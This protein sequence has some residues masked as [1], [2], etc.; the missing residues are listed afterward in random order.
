M[1]LYLPVLLL[2]KR[3]LNATPPHTPTSQYFMRKTSLIIS[4]VVF[5]FT[6]K[7]D[8]PKLGGGGVGAK[9]NQHKT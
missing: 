4:F 2:W 8:L 5:F 7:E 6:R 9:S 3:I 1:L